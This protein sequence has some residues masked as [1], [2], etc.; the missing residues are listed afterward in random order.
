MNAGDRIYRY[1]NTSTGPWPIAV[2]QPLTVV[3]VNRLTVT[4]RTDQGST[5]RIDPADIEGPWDY[6]E[7][8]NA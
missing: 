5:F 4:V 7:S 3:R 6:D 8:E 2:P 1:L